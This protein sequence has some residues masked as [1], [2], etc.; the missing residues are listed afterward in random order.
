MT[1]DKLE[2]L[3]ADYRRLQLL[4]GW[5]DSAH[6]NENPRRKLEALL[7]VSE[8]DGWLSEETILK[9]YDLIRPELDAARDRLEKEFEAA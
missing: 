3:T 7:E 5:L 2:K 6:K 4:G 1:E 8:V 9:C